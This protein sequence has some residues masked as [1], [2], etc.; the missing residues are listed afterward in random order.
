MPLCLDEIRPTPGEEGARLGPRFLLE[1]VSSIDVTAIGRF[2]RKRRD[3]EG[4]DEPLPLRAGPVSN[5]E[6]VPAGETTRDR[7]VNRLIR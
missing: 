2:S 3:Q 1:G 4:S 7:A 5:G 6:F